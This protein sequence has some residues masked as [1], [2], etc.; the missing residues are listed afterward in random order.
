MDP[1]GKGKGCAD[2]IGQENMKHEYEP[3]DVCSTKIKFEIKEGM[4][5][6]ISFEDGCDGNLKAISILL[7]NMKAEELIKKLKGVQCEDRGTS[8]TGQLAI[9][10]EKYSL[11]HKT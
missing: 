4:V 3:E 7:E 6:N 11:E 1:R 8:C 5:H 10:V 9:A 2:K